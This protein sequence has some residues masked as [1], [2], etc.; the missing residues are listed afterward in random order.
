MVVTCVRSD[1]HSFILDMHNA[2]GLFCGPQRFTYIAQF[3]HTIMTLFIPTMILVSQMPGRCK[4]LIQ[5]L[6]GRNREIIS[7]HSLT[8]AVYSMHS[9]S[10]ILVIAASFKII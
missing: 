8:S 2:K 5:V 10:C 1:L 7:G 9:N 4:K 3:F 6:Y